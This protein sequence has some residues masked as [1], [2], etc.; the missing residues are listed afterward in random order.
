MKKWSCKLPKSPCVLSDR[1]NYTFHLIQSNFQLKALLSDFI[2]GAWTPEFKA[3]LY[4]PSSKTNHNHDAPFGVSTNCAS[5]G[6]KSEANVQLHRF[7]DHLPSWQ[8][9]KFSLVS[10]EKNIYLITHPVEFLEFSMRHLPSDHSCARVN[11]FILKFLEDLR[12]TCLAVPTILCLER[13]LGAA[14]SP[15]VAFVYQ[16]WRPVVP[17]ARQG[18]CYRPV[19]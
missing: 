16:Q 13:V 5:Q 1:F 3:N 14:D 4:M 11:Y 6:L 8:T 15:N 17:A 7:R 12:P 18:C 19:E 9:V 2:L 10:L